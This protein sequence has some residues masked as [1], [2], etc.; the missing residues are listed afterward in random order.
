MKIAAIDIGS[1]AIRLAIANK[2]GDDISNIDITR[3]PLRL[4]TDSFSESGTFSEYILSY[5]ENIFMG[6]DEIMQKEGVKKYLCFATSAMRSA[7]NS[8]EFIKRVKKTSGIE[9]DVITG[10][11][12]AR[13]IQNAI[14]HQT[15]IKKKALLVDIGGG[16]VELTYLLD[17]KPVDSIS[18]NLG[19]VR[20]LN[21]ID[22]LHWENW[23]Q[24]VL[25]FLNEKRSDFDQFLNRVGNLRGLQIIGTGGNFRRFGKLRKKF[26]GESESN[27]IMLE[28]LRKFYHE[29]KK[30]KPIYLMREFDL[31][32]DRAEVLLPAMLIVDF[33]FKS[34]K[35]LR[36]DLPNAGL[37]H[38]ILLE[39]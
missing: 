6:L 15:K 18:F 39:I 7:S 13:V 17:G 26:L 5:A 31:K 22:H 20:I 19:T 3:V 34:E 24:E 21:I 23:E 11:E 16:S 8:K 9:I 38:G 37:I 25:K 30:H 14:S 36:I 27:F 12:E 1:N 2:H 33:L 10:I 35:S 4:G 32:P 29:N 28:E